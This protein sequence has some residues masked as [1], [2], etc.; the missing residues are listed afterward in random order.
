MCLGGG[1]TLIFIVLDFWD[2]SKQGRWEGG[3]T[4]QIAGGLKLDDRC[5]LFNPFYD[6]RTAAPAQTWGL[7]VGTLPLTL[8]LG[9]ASFPGPPLLLGPAPAA[10]LG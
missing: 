6:G 7:S 1:G 4:L 2:Q 8:F 9:A 5:S 3:M 10:S